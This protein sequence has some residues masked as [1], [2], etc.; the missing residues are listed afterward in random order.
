MTTIFDGP[1]WIEGARRTDAAR[2]TWEA[3][4]HAAAWSEPV[5]GDS[6]I[7]VDATIE[8]QTTEL[9]LEWFNLIGNLGARLGSDS[10]KMSATGENYSATEEQASQANSRFWENP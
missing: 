1:S 9:K 2:E 4:T 7:P 10:S 8:T 3:D 6:G 5:T